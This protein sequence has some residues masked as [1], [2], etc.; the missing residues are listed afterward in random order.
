[1]E[2]DG[3]GEDQDR[4]D[5]VG[6][7]GD[8]VQ[9]GQDGDAAEHDLADD[10]ADEAERQPRQVPPPGLADE[11]AEHGQDDRDRDDAREEAVHLLDRAV[12]A[13]DVD[14]AAPVALGPVR[15]AQTGAGQAHERAGHDD[16]GEGQRGQQGQ[17]AVRRRAEPP[18]AGLRPRRAPPPSAGPWPSRVVVGPAA[19]PSAGPSSAG[20]PRRT[21][22]RS[23]SPVPGAPLG[24]A[25]AHRRRRLPD[26]PDPRAARPTGDVRPQPLRPLLLQRRH[27]RRLARVRRGARALPE[28]P[29]DRRRVQR[30]RRRRAGVRARIGPLPARPRHRRRSRSPSRSSSPCGCCACSSTPRP[31]A[32]GPT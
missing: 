21:L 29:G 2:D 27:R 25:G 13:R 24:S 26:P 18:A 19:G 15:A 9:V 6:L 11:G 28:P 4:Q 3:V 32:C 7:D 14:E 20:T 17:A 30:G 22:G 5:E 12:G 10:A 1:M 31:T 8:G 16:H 23:P